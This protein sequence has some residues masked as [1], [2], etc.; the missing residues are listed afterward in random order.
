M[1]RDNDV[2]IV[3]SNIRNSHQLDDAVELVYIQIVRQAFEGNLCTF[4]YK[5]CCA[6]YK[7][8]WRNV[9]RRWKEAKALEEARD[10]LLEALKTYDDAARALN[11]RIK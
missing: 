10:N 11:S 4:V 3:K 5:L 7:Y 1:S 9:D 8:Y 6:P 2:S